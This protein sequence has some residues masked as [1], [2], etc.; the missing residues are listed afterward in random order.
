MTR[1]LAIASGKGGVGKTWFAIS[2]SQAL[3]RMNRR[4]LLVDC[5]VGLANVDVQL[6]LGVVTGL[7][8][9]V[10]GEI[11]LSRAIQTPDGIGFDVLPGRSGAVYSG[12]LDPLMTGW[13]GHELL[14]KSSGYDLIILD[15]PS[16]ADEGVRELMRLADA[17]IILTTG[18]P[19]ALA[20]AYGLIKA[21]RR[22]RVGGVPNIVVNFADDVAAGSQTQAGLGRICDRFLAVKPR[23]LGIVRRDSRVPEAICRQM[24]LLQCYPG[25]DAARDVV[26]VAETILVMKDWV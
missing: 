5:D 11:T 9:A 4:V 24:P 8:H 20:D 23:S 15:L 12:G 3:A 13:I 17:D 14:R 21:T 6:G 25:C 16:G 22:Y 7:H 10:M 1:T 26:A 2:L 18:E 19:T